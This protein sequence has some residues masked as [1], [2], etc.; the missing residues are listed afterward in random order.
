[1]PDSSLGLA[2]ETRMSESETRGRVSAFFK[3]AP[4]RAK[5]RLNGSSGYIQ[6]DGLVFIFQFVHGRF[7]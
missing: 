3:I 4:E 7:C 5:R 6:P 1:M 2:C